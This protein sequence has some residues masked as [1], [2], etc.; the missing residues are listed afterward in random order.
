M[1]GKTI[2]NMVHDPLLRNFRTVKELI[3]LKFIGTD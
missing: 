2:V 3:Y 1:A